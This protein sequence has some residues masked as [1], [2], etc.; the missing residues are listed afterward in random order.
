ME[1][2]NTLT[3][4]ETLAPPALAGVDQEQDDN[5][6]H[7]AFRDQHGDV[8]HV[9]RPGGGD[10]MDVADLWEAIAQEAGRAADIARQQAVT[11]G[12]GYR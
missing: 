7:L 3:R 11:A 12:G 6:L 8:T 1:P 10:P 5:G 2:M 4:T 9:L